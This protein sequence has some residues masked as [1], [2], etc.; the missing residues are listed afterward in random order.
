M[1]LFL[2][3]LPGGKGRSYLA[4]WVA[5]QFGYVGDTNAATRGGRIDQLEHYKTGLA[6]RE[7]DRSLVNNAAGLAPR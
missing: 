7:V 5:G 1:E 6:V 2:R 3:R 4:R